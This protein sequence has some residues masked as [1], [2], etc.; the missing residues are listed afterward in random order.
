MPHFL[1]SFGLI[2][3][4]LAIS[5]CGGGASSNDVVE[6]AKHYEE[7]VAEARKLG[8]WTSTEDVIDDAKG[9]A[10]VEAGRKLKAAL[11]ALEAKIK[12]QGLSMSYD[13]SLGVFAESLKLDDRGLP[14]PSLSK[15]PKKIWTENVRPSVFD[16]DLDSIQ[17]AMRLGKPDFGRDWEHTPLLY[18]AAI[19]YGQIRTAIRLLCRR[20]VAKAEQNLAED[21]IANLDTALRLGLA[22]G[23]EPVREGQHLE[24]FAKNRVMESW[25]ECTKTLRNN[26]VFRLKSETVLLSSMRPQ[27]F[28]R[29]INIEIVTETQLIERVARSEEVWKSNRREGSKIGFKLADIDSKTARRGYPVMSIAMAKQFLKDYELGSGEQ[30][31]KALETKRPKQNETWT[32]GQVLG[33]IPDWEVDHVFRSNS[34]LACFKVALNLMRRA[35]GGAYPDKLNPEESKILDPMTGKQFSYH[36]DQDGVVIYSEFRT[37]KDKITTI[38]FSDKP[39]PGEISIRLR[40]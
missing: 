4:I 26:E 19:E 15:G 6:S 10:S 16:K 33:G 7:T 39:L 34:R 28:K 22:C 21:A 11:K 40:N 12:K 18:T 35:R 23:S 24:S 36:K 29:S 37:L 38:N 30:V 9:S 2:L 14:T 8:L 27:S 17:S 25:S 3:P 5:G 32:P 1:R 20:A 31:L 13:G